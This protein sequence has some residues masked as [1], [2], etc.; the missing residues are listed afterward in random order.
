VLEG[1]DG[2]RSVA[3]LGATLRV[4]MSR[5]VEEPETAV[6]DALARRGVEARVERTRPSLEDVFVDATRL[7]GRP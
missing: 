6:R 1:V 2:V 5:E 3:Q 7:R 4:Q